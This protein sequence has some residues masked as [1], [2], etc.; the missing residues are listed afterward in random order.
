DGEEGLVDLLDHVGAGLDEDVGAVLAPA[1]V[2]L[3][4]EI[5]GVERGAH[6]AVEDEDAPGEVLE[7]AAGHCERTPDRGERD[8]PSISIHP[9]ERMKELGVV[10]LTPRGP[11][12]S[13]I[14]KGDS[15]VPDDPLDGALSYRPGRRVRFARSRGARVGDV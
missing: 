4:A 9:D 13:W 6:G 14:S 12:A 5:A 10:R 3:D 8:P 15:H 2:V 7:G 11:G 1:V